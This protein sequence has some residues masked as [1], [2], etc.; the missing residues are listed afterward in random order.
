MEK[1]ISGDN[2][3][4]AKEAIKYISEKLNFDKYKHSLW[5]VFGSF[6]INR[7]EQGSDL[8]LIAI[9]DYFAKDTRVVD[10]FKGVS[11]HFTG[12][13]MSILKEDGENR[14]YGS[15][16]S[17]KII[18]PHIFLYGNNEL[19]NEALNQAGKFIAPLAG[20][21]GGMTNQDQFT[22]SQVTA[23][24]F[25]AYLSTDPSFDSYFLNYFVS[26]NFNKIWAALCASTIE[27]L[28]ASNTVGQVDNKY[29]FIDRFLDY[30]SFHEERMKIS[31]RHWSYGAV[32]HGGDRRFQD[33]IFTK[34]KEK[35]KRIDPLGNK[36]LDMVRFLKEQ[37]KLPDIYI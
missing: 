20:F 17:G 32:C 5:L 6:V 16:F 27:M 37:S 19:K 35:M 10:S 2:L 8:D 9:D 29:Y 7:N 25:I 33:M 14:L 4:F 36:Y 28:K 18:N 34:A 15:Y 24:V 22:D 23:L 12:I 30:K 1:V 3:A 13:N 26:P 11:I 21:L 31:A